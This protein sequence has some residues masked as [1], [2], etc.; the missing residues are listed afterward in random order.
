MTIYEKLLKARQDFLSKGIT[1]S[2]INRHAEFQYYELSDIVPLANEILSKHGLIYTVSFD[3]DFAYGILTDISDNKICIKFTLPLQTIAE[4]AK[5]RMNEVQAM[6]A[7]ITYYRRYLYFVLFDIIDYEQF[8]SQ[9]PVTS[10]ATSKAPKTPTERAE[11]AETL[12][13]VQGQATELQIK[14]LKSSLKTLKE[15]CPDKRQYIKDIVTKTN[16]FK[17]ISKEECEKIVKECALFVKE[18]EDAQ[19]GN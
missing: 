14:A 1:K 15:Y 12:T 5:F 13:N 9:V 8:D 3:S 4:P 16:S 6:G 18:V 2:G 10:A 17:N 19:N 11:I 7:V